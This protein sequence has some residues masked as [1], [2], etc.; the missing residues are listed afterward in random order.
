MFENW[1]RLILLTLSLHVSRISARFCPW[2]WFRPA[3]WSVRTMI[4][5]FWASQRWFVSELHDRFYSFLEI[6]RVSHVDWENSVITFVIF[7]MSVYII[8][9]LVTDFQLVHW[10]LLTSHPPSWS[11]PKTTSFFFLF[12]RPESTTW[13]SIPIQA[14]VCLFVA[15]QIKVWRHNSQINQNWGFL[16]SPS[17]LAFT[18]KFYPAASVLS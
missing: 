14:Q 3:L 15:I 17:L 10:Y 13:D 11:P 1:G 2:Y 6:G 16:S 8:T 7:D 9:L 18:I 5:G 12:F 4:W